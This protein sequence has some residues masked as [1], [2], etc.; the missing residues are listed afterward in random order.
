ML[1]RLKQSH[2]LS[3][4]VKQRETAEISTEVAEVKRQGHTKT[5]VTL[6]SSIF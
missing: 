6:K 4:H 2:G 3:Q 1:H 5:Q